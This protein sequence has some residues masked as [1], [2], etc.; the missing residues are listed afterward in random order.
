MHRSH[1]S[2]LP[3][4]ARSSS[5]LVTGGALSVTWRACAKSA[6]CAID[7]GSDVKKN[8]PSSEYST[9]YSYNFRACTPVSR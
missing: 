8:A 1:F 3:R 4:N 5:N 9:E 2:T 7:S 6:A